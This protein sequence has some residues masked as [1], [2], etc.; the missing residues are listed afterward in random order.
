LAAEL[1]EQGLRLVGLGGLEPPPS[2]LSG[3]DGLALCYPA[4]SQAGRLRKCHR[5]GVN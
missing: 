1:L 2:S 5:D 4:F 3:M